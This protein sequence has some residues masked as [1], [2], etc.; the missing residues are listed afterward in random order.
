MITVILN[1]IAGGQSRASATERIRQTSAAIEA[2]GEPGEVM[3]TEFRGHARELALGAVKNGSRLIVACGGDGTINEVASVLAFGQVPFAMV[4]AGS[5]NGLA[6]EL[7][8]ATQP[9]RAIAEAV[10]AIPKVIDAGELG[11]RLF[12]NVAGFGF[13]AHVAACL[14]RENPSR[15]G[16]AGYIRLGLREMFAYKPLIYTINGKATGRPAVV[17]TLANSPQWGNGF[18]IAPAARVDDGQ[19][20]LVVVEE[21]NRFAS[22]LAAPRLRLGGLERLRQVT[23]SQV[24]QVTISGESPMTFHVDGEPQQGGTTI[25]GRVHPGALRVCV[26]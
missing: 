18:R 19:L 1:P 21:S 16:L 10:R 15:R 24:Q 25:E 14:E 12:F 6:R 8:V 3:V 20:D 4:P 23:I 7:G 22:M 17:V 13:D 2:C 11:G 9:A 5:G 26:R